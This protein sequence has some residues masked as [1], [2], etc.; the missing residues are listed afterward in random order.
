MKL[1]IVYVTWGLGKR[2]PTCGMNPHNVIARNARAGQLGGQ[3]DLS[4]VRDL[5]LRKACIDKT[6]VLNLPSE[7]TGYENTA[8]WSDSDTSV[9][10]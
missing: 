4:S 1:P 6:D 10:G 3:P 2:H 9:R 5:A 8:A 7:S